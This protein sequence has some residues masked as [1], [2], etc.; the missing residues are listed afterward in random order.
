MSLQN[1][2]VVGGRPSITYEMN[3]TDA[4]QI[5]AVA[6]QT[7]DTGADM[8]QTC[9]SAMITVEDNEIRYAF[10][11]A[12]VKDGAGELGHPGGDGSIIKLNSHKSVRDFQFISAVAGDHAKL[13]ITIGF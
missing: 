1:V 11:V 10:G 12:P 6:K 8:E 5:I 3:S 7:Q 2:A 13:M 9:K 4:A